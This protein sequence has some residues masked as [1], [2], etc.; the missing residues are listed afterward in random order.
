MYLSSLFPNV[1]YRV[2]FL[3]AIRGESIAAGKAAFL[4]VRETRITARAPLIFLG[5]DTA[6]NMLSSALNTHA[7]VSFSTNIVVI[8]PFSL[9]V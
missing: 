2:S 8:P 6:T 9:S 7:N 5:K 1:Q 4:R 3:T